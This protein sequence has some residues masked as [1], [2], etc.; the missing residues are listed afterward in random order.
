MKLIRLPA[1]T[2]DEIIIWQLR[3]GR[4][5]IILLPG[6]ALL[7]ESL[8]C[9]APLKKSSQ[10]KKWLLANPELSQW[11]PEKEIIIRIKKTGTQCSYWAVSIS[12]WNYWMQLDQGR[13]KYS[14]L[15]PDWMLLPVPRDGE[16]TALHVN[17]FVVFRYDS[18]CGGA[19]P[20]S[21][22]QVVDAFL[23]RWFSLPALGVTRI[24]TI[25]FIR[26]QAR[27]SKV[28]PP[29]SSIIALCNKL[30][31]PVIILCTTLT[32]VL[33]PEYIWLSSMRSSEVQQDT[34]T[35][36]PVE[37]DR[38]Q[39]S[40]SWL[41]DIQQQGPVQLELMHL[42]KNEVEYRLRTPL[43]CEVMEDRLKTHSLVFKFVEDI[44]GCLIEGRSVF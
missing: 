19:L 1:R 40:L 33:A 18:E 21:D 20:E 5:T 26:E 22:K 27:N 9:P 39:H 29:R 23:P 4:E 37:P 36:P 42:K 6:E 17:G 43:N 34:I 10:I 31:L 3:Q 15:V 24:L 11:D 38:L 35:R 8:E 25:N 14:I 12:L 16:L 28:M 30:L 44:E 13:Y 32:C 41:Q 7:C 2:T